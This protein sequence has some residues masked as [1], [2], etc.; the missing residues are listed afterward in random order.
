MKEKIIIIIVLSIAISCPVFGQ[1][2]GGTCQVYKVVYNKGVKVDSF[3]L[4]ELQ[5]DSSRQPVLE[6]EYFNK[7]N[8]VNFKKKYVRVGGQLKKVI[9]D[10]YNNNVELTSYLYDS[11]GRVSKIDVYCNDELCATQEFVYEDTNLISL[12]R[13]TYMKGQ[14][15][16]ESREF[17]AFDSGKIINEIVVNHS[18]DTTFRGAYNYG[19]SNSVEYKAYG[20]DG[21]L[22]EWY[23][24]YFNIDSSILKRVYLQDQK[25][26]YTEIS[27]F[28]SIKRLIKRD[29]IN[30]KGDTLNTEEFLYG[31]NGLIRKTLSKH[32]D[33]VKE[34]TEYDE[35][36][37]EIRKEEFWRHG[38]LQI[39]LPYVYSKRK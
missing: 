7:S 23:R 20:N 34:V 35:I 26:L 4:Q 36:T 31:E 17:R 19:S 14:P 21:S 1:T 15:F 29:R 6:V 13:Y 24:S 25:V 18:G 10:D 37:G 9:I 33:S 32:R 12:S 28:D 16:L 27:Q 5:F 39:R 8:A 3:L 11:S 38:E 30:R 2:I 22:I